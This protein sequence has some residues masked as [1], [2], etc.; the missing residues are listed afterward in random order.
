MVLSRRLGDLPDT[1]DV[2]G[3]ARVE[4]LTVGRPG[5]RHALRDEHFRLG[6]LGFELVH[7]DF[8]LQ[9]LKFVEKEP[10]LVF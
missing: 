10:L 9:I 7:D 6:N 1:D 5:E 2:V 4:R 8:V 3:V